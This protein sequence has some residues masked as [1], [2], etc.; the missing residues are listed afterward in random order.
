MKRLARLTI[1][2][3]HSGKSTFAKLLKSNLP[4]SIVI[5]Q[6]NHAT[7]LNTYYSSL[8]PQTG[9]NTLK[10]GLSKFIIQYAIE[11]AMKD[12]I[13]CNAN[14][15][16]DQRKSLIE[17]FFP[18]NQF[19]RVFVYFEIT[20]ELLQERILASNRKTNIFRDE[21]MTFKELLHNQGKLVQPTE[22]EADYLFFITNTTNQMS[23]IEQINNLK[24]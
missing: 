16:K 24:R 10:T 3:T 9:D 19:I 23:V 18:Q 14:L 6:D 17:Q 4:N 21:T 15:R 1:G 22:D 20:D 13:L 7:F 5:D 12:I 8:V 11:H 2:K